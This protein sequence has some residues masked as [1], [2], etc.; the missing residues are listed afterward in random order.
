MRLIVVVAGLA[1]IAIS[2]SA[3]GGRTAVNPCRGGNLT[4]TFGV[5]L[6]S[7]GAGSISYDL[8]VR[9]RSAAS[10]YVSGIPRLQLLG[11]SGT[12]LPTKVIRVSAG[13]PVPARLVLRPGAYAA[14]TAR[15]SPDIPGPG[16]PQR[17]RCEP[18]TYNVRVTPASN[19][20]LV[21]PAKPPTS[22]C[23]HGTIQLTVL[24]AG[25]HGPRS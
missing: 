11:K 9:N 22:V 2:A 25:R 1:A 12:P 14:A 18:L 16:E 3:A 23:E 19:G 17:G 21:V 10:C 24:V 20:S 5:V 4:G 7:P 6:G 13:R 15:F 8:R